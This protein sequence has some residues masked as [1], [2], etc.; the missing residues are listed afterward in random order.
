MFKKG[1]LTNEPKDSSTY[2]KVLLVSHGLYIKELINVFVY[3]KT[4]NLLERY[5]TNN[6]CMYRIKVYCPECGGKCNVD[7][8]SNINVSFTLFNEIPINPI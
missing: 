7:T 4:G 8:H 6:T 2:T 1:E 3:M 5:H